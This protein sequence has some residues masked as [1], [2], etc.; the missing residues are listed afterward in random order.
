MKTAG[1]SGESLVVPV[2]QETKHK[3]SQIIRGE[4]PGVFRCELRDE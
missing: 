2:S 4:I 3:T 1:I